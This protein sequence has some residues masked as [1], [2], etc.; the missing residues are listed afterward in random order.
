MHIPDG[1]LSP[2]TCAGLYAVSAPFWYVALKRVQKT[3]STKTVPLISLFA[4]FSFVIMMFNLPLPGGTTG[5]AVG[6]G[7]ATVVMGPWVSMLAVSIA[8]LIQALFFGDGGITTFGANSFNMAIVGS[9]AAAAVYSLIAGRSAVT[10]TRRMVAAG[11]AGYTAIN[12]SAFCAAV[13]FGIQPL[14]FRDASGA[15]LYA[16]YPLAVAIPAMMIGHLTLAGTAEAVISAGVTR[17]LQTT[18][19]EMLHERTAPL[20]SPSS[21][22]FWRAPHQLWLALVVLVLL[23]PLGILAVGQ[24]WGEWRVEDFLSPA[25]RQRIAA[26]SQHELPISSAPSGLQHFAGVWKAPLTGYSPSFV[27]SVSAGYLLSAVAGVAFTLLLTMAAARLLL[28]SKRR[29]KS[30]LEKTVNDLFKL[31]QDAIF[32]ENIARS[33]GL[34]QLIDPR[35]KLV[36]LGALLLSTVAVHRLSV[37]LGAHRRWRGACSA[38]ANPLANFSHPN[39]AS[40]PGLHGSDR[41][42]G[43][44]SHRRADRIPATGIAL[45]D[46]GTGPHQRGVSRLTRGRGSHFRG[47]LGAVHTLESPVAIAAFLSDAGCA[48]ADHRND[49][50][51]HLSTPASRAEHV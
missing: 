40:G 46:I 17:Y 24:A 15:P 41:L 31:M 14:L 4:A 34:L 5:H 51:L 16:P 3:V 37:L 25:A 32:A 9:L 45:A 29:R 10:S 23:T 47:A 42:P 27:S 44:F 35:V 12:I 36:G 2:S 33:K 6:V 11:F 19:P 30:I 39:M 50:P 48:G 22:T 21:Q 43:T 20:Q 1:Y 13:E 38:F 26:I 18:N 49:I 7:I 8:L 28:R